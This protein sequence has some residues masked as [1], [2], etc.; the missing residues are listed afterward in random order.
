MALVIE[1]VDVWAASIRDEIGGL[2]QLLA[3][4][5]DAGADLDFVLARRTAEE[6]GMG[7]AFFTPLRGDTEV[8]A[9]TDLGSNVARSVHSVRVEGE[10][11]PGIAAEMTDQL[12]AQGINLRG[13][14]AAVIGP[15]FI[16]YI[17][18]DSSDD[19]DAAVAILEQISD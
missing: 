7:V 1:R 15:R 16:A 6:P 12:A 18:L 9:A 14:S 11:R 19:A 5:R 2:G 4:L 8:A 17:G 13:F 3:S 10:N